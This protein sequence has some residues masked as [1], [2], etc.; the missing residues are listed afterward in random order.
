MSGVSG[1]SGMCPECVRSVSGACV[2]SVSGLCPMVSDVVY[3]TT[4]RSSCPEVS[5]V[6]EECP[7]LPYLEISKL[8]PQPSAS[9]EPQHHLPPQLVGVHS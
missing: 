8:N 3:D 7:S 4:S 1:V 6:S 9:P 5:G 2:R